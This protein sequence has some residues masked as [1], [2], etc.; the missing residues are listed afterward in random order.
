MSNRPSYGNGFSPRSMHAPGYPVYPQPGDHDQSQ[1]IILPLGAH[2]N[3]NASQQQEGYYNQQQAHFPPLPGMI[4]PPGFFN[5]PPY[6]VQQ[7]HPHSHVQS[8]PSPHQGMYFNQQHPFYKYGPPPPPPPP[9]Q[10]YQQPPPQYTTGRPMYS[11]MTRNNLPTPQPLSPPRVAPQQTKKAK[12]VPNAQKKYLP[13]NPSNYINDPEYAD[14][15]PAGIQNKAAVKRERPLL[16][17]VKRAKEAVKTMF[18]QLNGNIQAMVLRLVLE[19]SIHRY[20][21]IGERAKL[22][23]Y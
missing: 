18:P 1:F 17:E 20:H 4:P 3:H 8:P 7:Q 13:L 5:Q 12:E 14:E 22:F 15:V 21:T 10:H 6:L 11:Q 16:M 23:F 2:I 9:H 19:D